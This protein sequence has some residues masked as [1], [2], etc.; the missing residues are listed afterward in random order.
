MP[1]RL[2]Y[3]CVVTLICIQSASLALN[4]GRA[5]LTQA[6][7]SRLS[8]A[9]AGMV[10][11]LVTTEPL[12]IGLLV[13]PTPFGYVSGYKNRFEEM[14]KFLKKAGDDVQ[15]VTADREVV[16]AK[17]DEV[18]T[19]FLGFPIAT[20]RGWELPMYDQVTLT[21][22]FAGETPKMIKR[23]RPDVIHASSPSAII[24]PAIVWAKI[25]HIPLVISY[26]TDLTV[27]SRTYVPSPPFPLWFG[28]WLAKL[29]I[30]SLH[31]MADLTLCTSP[32]LMSNLQEMGLPASHLSVWQKGINA[33]RFNPAFKSVAM[34]S[35][36]SDGHP[37]AP[38]LLY[39]GRLGAEKRLDRL[40]D[41]LE[42]IPGTR[43][44][45]VGQGPDEG[46][47]KEL[48][49]DSPVVFTG[50]L[51]GDELSAAFASADVFTMP[52]DS[53]TLGFVVLEAM[54]SGVPV[55]TVAAGGVLDLVEEGNNG[56]L[57]D[58]DDGMVEFTAKTRKLLDNDEERAAM[59]KRSRAYAEDWSWEAATSKLRNL[60]YRVAMRNHKQAALKS[61]ISEVEEKELLENA[62]SY[63]AHLA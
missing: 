12:K 35:K 49:R 23:F 6:S 15:V 27:Y 59:A 33:E 44:A 16:T 63:M 42:A 34:R 38:L 28:P 21:Y 11:A 20:N 61:R 45:L 22:D 10:P 32:Q 9:A 3:A 24:Y 30:T 18:A 39:V 7:R 43:L 37:D 26:H 55:V 41:V 46:R 62:G 5:R 53:E 29:L 57:A 19:D 13:E 56:Y 14:L 52:S 25:F 48:Y 4:P 36:M 47:L 60:Q 54:A 51:T 31:G 8:D 40:K 1:S 58:N 50:Q 17:K 2:L